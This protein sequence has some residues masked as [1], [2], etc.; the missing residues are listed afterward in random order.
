VERAVLRELEKGRHPGLDLLEHAGMAWLKDIKWPFESA[1]FDGKA[2]AGDSHEGIQAVSLSASG[3]GRY[4]P[5]ALRCPPPTRLRGTCCR[6]TSCGEE[7]VSRSTWRCGHSV[8]VPAPIMMIVFGLALVA[9]GVGT[10]KLRR[11]T[12][13]RRDI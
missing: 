3:G 10:Q 7:A 6:W 4:G 2:C 5:R 12:R 11:M 9:V 13:N 1:I 8:E